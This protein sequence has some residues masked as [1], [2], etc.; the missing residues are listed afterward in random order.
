M[1]EIAILGGGIIGL[2]LAW[3]L[4]QRGV[5][6]RV[7]DRGGPSATAA[8]AGMLAPSFEAEGLSSGLAPPLQRAGFKSLA[9]WTEFA[10]ELEAESG[11]FLDFRRDGIFRV[12][13]NAARLDAIFALTQSLATFGGRAER[14]SAA[15][16]A[17]AEPG[18]ARDLAGAV[19][20]AGEG[21]VDPRQ[22]RRALVT[23]LQKRGRAVER[24][25][26][27]SLTAGDNGVDIAFDDGASVRA[28][29]AVLASGAAAALAGAELA[30]AVFPVK[31]EAFAL[32]TPTSLLSRVVRGDGAYLCPKADHRLV[33]GATSLPHEESEDVD[34]ARLANLR[35][36]AEEIAPGLV[37]AREIER[38][39]GLRPGTPDEAPL[40]GPARDMPRLFYALGHYRN[41]VLLSPWTADVLAR[42]LSGE[43]DPLLAAFAPDRFHC[44]RQDHA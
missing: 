1:S 7:F 23:A 14:V 34:D 41:G 44:G 2:S 28:E 42:R 30:S 43:V 37:R 22:V 15:A 33:V 32:A 5:A 12:S 26:V 25:T 3:R 39:S 40:L 17:R 13:A 29:Y 27:R 36:R 4:A 18:L 11:V 9:L 20:A 24:R 35:S 38:W 19:F 6:V 21:E 10:R 16:L 31:G 8:A